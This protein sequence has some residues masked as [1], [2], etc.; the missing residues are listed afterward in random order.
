MLDRP[1]REPN[2]TAGELQ[3]RGA[4]EMK[5]VEWKGLHMAQV[6]ICQS[7][8]SPKAILVAGPYERRDMPGS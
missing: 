7:D 5:D 8:W 2:K 3:N 6:P 1:M 4:G